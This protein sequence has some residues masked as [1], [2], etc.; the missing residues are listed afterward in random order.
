MATSTFLVNEISATERD[1]TVPTEQ[2]QIMFPLKY[3]IM[4][5]I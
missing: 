1:I 3:K 4:Q 5:G 2:V